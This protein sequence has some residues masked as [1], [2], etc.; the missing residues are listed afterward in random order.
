MDTRRSY[1]YASPATLIAIIGDAMDSIDPNAHPLSVTYL[2]VK[3]IVTDA[4]DALIANVGAEDAISM[5]F[6]AGF[7][8]SDLEM[9]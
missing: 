2:D 4:W 8:F 7:D 3:A 9:N 6:D 5:A 1:D